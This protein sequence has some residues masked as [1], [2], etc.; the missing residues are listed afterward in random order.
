MKRWLS[1]FGSHATLAPD[2]FVEGA[3][4]LSIGDAEQ[5]HVNLEHPGEIFYEYLRRLANHIDVFADPGLKLVELPES[6]WCCGSAGVYNITQPEMS[7]ELRRQKADAVA[8]TG[9][10]VGT[11]VLVLLGTAARGG[12]MPL[13][14]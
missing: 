6:S 10:T 7:G 3:W 11:G 4:V 9:A 13:Y 8:A 2:A 1:G 5:S 12:M 14:A